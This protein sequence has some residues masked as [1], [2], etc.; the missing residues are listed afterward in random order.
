MTTTTTSD[1]LTERAKALKLHGLLAHWD[2]VMDAPWL[3]PLIRWEEAERARRGLQ[4][5]LSAARLGR[6]KP[7]ADFDWNWPKQCDRQAI[8]ELMQLGF[9][10]EAANAVLVGPNG[11]GKSTI[12]R[13]IAH[14]AVLAGHSVLFTNAAAMLNELA[15]QDGDNALRRRLAL[16]ARPRL[17]VIDEIGYLSYSNRHAD[18][19]FEIVSRRYEEKSTIITTNKPFAE[20]NQVFPNASCVVSLVDRLVHHA[21]II[22]IEGESYRLKEAK[23]QSEKRRQ[24]RTAAKR[25]STKKTPEDH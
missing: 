19:L 9:L 25:K 24:K 2:E 3:G 4:R 5:R 8:E 16:Y 1:S 11:V 17:L 22:P 7:L 15:A 18:L 23:E 6:F 21:E 10:E 12:A 14:Q 20:W 13:N